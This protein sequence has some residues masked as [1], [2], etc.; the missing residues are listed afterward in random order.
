M[1]TAIAC[2]VWL[3]TTLPAIWD[4][5]C[6][7]PCFC[8][9]DLQRDPVLTVKVSNGKVVYYMC[10]RKNAQLNIIAACLPLLQ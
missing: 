3:R 5:L 2:G 8:L 6:L 10:E 9:E 1:N 4:A 7:Y